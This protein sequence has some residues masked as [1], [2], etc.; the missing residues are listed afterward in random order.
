[1]SARARIVIVTYNAGAFVDAAIESALAQT[2][3]CEVVI[4]DNASS[5][6]TLAYL[7]TLADPRIRVITRDRNRGPSAARNA[8]LAAARADIVAFLDSDDIYRAGRLAAPL[9]A[10]AA[11]CGLVA[12]LSSVASG[13]AAR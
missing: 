2:V 12:T 1:M 11:D 4:V 7:A 13:I 6:G 3:P 9:A 8:G 5:D 10:F